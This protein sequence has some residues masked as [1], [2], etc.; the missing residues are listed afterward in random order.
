MCVYCNNCGNEGHIYRHCKYPVLSYGIVCIH[1]NKILMI[2]RKDSIC[3]IE[4]IRGKYKLDNK[5]YIL[6]LLN[7]CSI[8]ERNRL[9]NNSFDWL[10]NTLW[11]SGKEKKVQTDRMIKEN[12]IPVKNYLKN[13]NQNCYLN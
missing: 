10:W 11:F 1:T 12:I 8:E 3:Y 2:Q 5:S 9:K 13:Y 7:R 4:F 6:N